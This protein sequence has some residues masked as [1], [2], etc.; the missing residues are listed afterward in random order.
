MDE[1]STNP[2]RILLT[3]A[4]GFLGQ[5]CTDLIVQQTNFELCCTSQSPQ[6]NPNKKGY[7]FVQLDLLDQLALEDLIKSFR[8]THI[9]HCAAL[10]SVEVCESSPELCDRLNVQLPAQLAALAKKD[11]IHLCFLST[12]FVFD[13]QQGPYEETAACN[14]CNAYGLSKLKAERS[15]ASSGCRFAI[16]RTIL[17]YGVIADKKRSNLVLWAK[18]KLEAAEQIKVVSDQWRMPTWVDD[19]AQ[20]CLLVVKTSAQGIYHISSEKRYS[21]LEAVYEIADYWNLDK[22]LILSIKAAEIGQENNRPKET[23]FIIEKSKKELGFQP[24]TFKDSL[25]II[26]QQIKDL[27]H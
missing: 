25:P 24:T 6:K 1:L 20:A 21:I 17:V 4:N 11:N 15:I 13:G 3:G 12:D 19:L 8:P 5:K 27:T 2:T 26:D 16:L 23:G 22:N 7:S 9:I 14:P 18:N 10:T